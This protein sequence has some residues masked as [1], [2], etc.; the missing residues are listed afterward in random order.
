MTTLWIIAGASIFVAW[1]VIKG[2]TWFK[3]APY[4]PDIGFYKFI[5]P[6]EIA[7]WKKSETILWQRLKAALG[8]LGLLLPQV[9][10]VDLNAVLPF[11]PE[12]YRLMVAAIPSV[13]LLLDGIVGEM[14]RNRTSRP[15]ELVAVP[16]TKPI[17]Q[18]VAAAVAQ[19]DAIKEAAVDVVKEAK[20]EGAV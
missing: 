10:A 7:L 17:P 15:L 14:L 11:V 6:I 19:A 9:G 4:L 13:A 5:E 18:E 16:E 12:D 8:S 3:T 20:A 1:Y 2:R